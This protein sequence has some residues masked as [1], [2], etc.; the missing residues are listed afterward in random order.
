M[1]AR[2]E[3][4]R[5]LAAEGT[6]VVSGAQYLALCMQN[7]AEWVHTKCCSNVSH[8]RM[9][10][11][12]QLF[13]DGVLKAPHGRVFPLEQAADAV[14]ESMRHGKGDKVLLKG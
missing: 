2:T 8:S 3:G 13:V 11:S 10:V 7:V 14:E 6:G 1:A 4:G 5:H 9:E 12:L